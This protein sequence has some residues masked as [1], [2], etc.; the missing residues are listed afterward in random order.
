[1]ADRLVLI[2]LIHIARN[3]VY[4]FDIGVKQGNGDM[5]Q[6]L[7]GYLVVGM[8]GAHDEVGN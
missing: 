4:V 5:K 6:S 2:L 1:M 3:S 7:D 8:D